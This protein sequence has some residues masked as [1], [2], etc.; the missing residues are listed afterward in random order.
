MLLAHLIRKGWVRLEETWKIA[1]IFET[2]KALK[3]Q[4][5]DGAIFVEL[6]SSSIDMADDL[7][8]MDEEYKNNYYQEKHGKLVSREVVTFP[9]ARKVTLLPEGKWSRSEKISVIVRSDRFPILCELLGNYY[10]GVHIAS[11]EERYRNLY[12]IYECLSEEQ[13]TELKSIRH[14]LSHSRKKMT[15]KTTVEILEA[16][17]GDVKINLSIYK[18]AKVFRKKMELLKDKS[19]KLLIKE[20]LK[21]LPS[22]KNFFDEYYMPSP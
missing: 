1:D 2:N 19:E 10:K 13:D 7:Q 21:I 16:L 22:E 3:K 6:V 5:E 12:Q 17:F 9:F 11:R 20:I 8:V 14:S 4:F 15:N 18:H